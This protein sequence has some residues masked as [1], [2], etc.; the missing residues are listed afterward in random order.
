MTV[1]SPENEPSKPRTYS[2]SGSSANSVSCSSHEP[3]GSHADCAETKL[4]SRLVLNSFSGVRLAALTKSLSALMSPNP[5]LAIF[6][7]SGFL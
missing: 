1:A 5:G 2:C 6:Q 4:L 7:V 3:E